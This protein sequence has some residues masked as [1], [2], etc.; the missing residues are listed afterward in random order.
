MQHHAS[1][2]LVVAIIV[3]TLAV[4]GIGAPR[5]CDAG[6]ELLITEFMALNTKTL[7]DE[8]GDYSDWIEIYNPCLADVDL[9]GWYLTD[10]EANLTKWQFPSVHL[11][12]GEYLRLFA[13][14]KNRAVAGAPL[15]TNFKLAS[16]G[17][18][19]ALVKPDG[20]TVAH[21]FSPAYPPQHSDVSYGLPQ[22]A[23]QLVSQGATAS[24]RVPTSDDS[25]LGTSW[26]A[27]GFDDSAWAAG[28]TGL[29][30]TASGAG[31]FAVTYYKA[32]ILVPDLATAEGVISDP[33]TQATVATEQ[34]PVINYL[35]TGGSAHY[36]N[37]RPFPGT[38]IGVDAD[39]FVVEATG[40]ILIPSAGPW[41]F[42]VNSDDGFSLDLWREPHDF[43]FS[44]SYPSP[45]GPAD[46]F[47]VFNIPEPGAY[48]VRLVFYER[49]GGSEVE[50]FAAQGSYSSFSSAF[51]LVGDAANGGLPL[52]NIGVE[53]KTNVQAAMQNVN[54]SL[55]SRIRFQVADPGRLSLLTLRMA[56]EDGFV[57]Y[58]NGVEVA[59]RDAPSSVSWNSTALSDR[60]TGDAGAFERIDLTNFLGLLQP[61]TNVLA[62]HGLNDA[63]ADGDFLVLP[64]LSAVEIT[65]DTGDRRY[66]TPATPGTFNSSGYPGV[67]GSPTFS[68]SS[69]VFTDSFSLTLTT[70]SPT[71]VVRYTLDGSEPSAT[72]GAV[73]SAPILI[74]ASTRIRARAFEAGLAPSSVITRFY[75]KLDA[76]V[77]GF[78]SNLPVLILD[79]FGDGVNQT[80]QTDVLT[81]IIPTVGGRASITGSPDF[82][83]YAGLRLRGSSSLGFPKN[84]YFLEIWDEDRQDRDV[85]F[86]GLPPQ[87]DWI[88]YG[89]Y[90][91]KSLMRNF[92]AYEWSNDIGRYAVR[93]RFVELY[94]R[95]A[96][97]AVSASD[98]YGV[99][100]LMEKI[101]WDVNRVNITQL[102]PTDSAPPEVTGGYIIKK[103]RLDPGDLGFRTIT[104]Q[105][106]NYVF[107]KEKNITTAQAAYLK[108]Y[109]DEFE[110]VLYGANFA[111]P[112][113]GYAKY[114]DVDSFIDHHIL[115]ELTKNIDGFR[116]S[117]FM[118]KDRNGKLNMGPL[119]DFDLALGNANYLNGWLPDG[120]Y[121]DQLNDGDYP[122]W[123]RLFSDPE[124]TQRY[125]D[126]WFAL[127]GGPLAT[128]KLL[129]DVDANAAL[130]GESE[131]R[132]FQR[133]PVLGVYVWPN[134]YIGAAYQDEIDWMKQWITGRVAWIDSQFVAPPVFNHAAGQ[135]PKWFNLTISASAGVIYYTLDGT[136]P[137]L[138]G[139][140]TSPSAVAYAGPL[141]IGAEARIRTRA[142]NGAI[143]SAINDATF[144][145]VPLVYVNE[146]LPQNVNCQHDEHGEFD[147]WIE[148]Y[149][150]ETTTADLS[151][152]F[153]TDDPTVPHK[154]SIPAGTKLCGL[155]VLL[156]W[157]DNEPGEGDLHTN[158]RLNPAG[159]SVLLFDQA[160]NLADSL[161][162]PALNV[163]VSYGRSPDGTSNLSPFFYATPAAPNAVA[164][165]RILLDEYNAVL[166]TKYLKNNGSDS[167]FGT[168][169]G[170][171]GDWFELVVVQDHLDIRGWKVLV[172]DNNVNYGPL[173]FTDAAILSD[174][175]SGTIIT[176]AADVPSNVSYD[177]AGGDW[178][179]SL[180]AG[181]SG[182][183]LYISAVPFS[184]SQQN[185]QITILDASGAL[186]FGPAGEGISPISGIGNDEVFKLQENPGPSATPFSTNYAAGSTSTFGTPNS[187][188]GGSYSQDFSVLRS[189]VPGPC[190]T[191]AACNDA[192]PCTDDACVGSRCQNTPNAAA[193][194]DGDPYTTNDACA[195]RVCRG[196]AA[197]GSCVSDCDCD[198]GSTCTTDSCVSRG[199]VNSLAPEGTRC[200]DANPCTVADACAAGVCQGAPMNCDDLDACTTDSCT[201][202]GCSHAVNGVCGIAGSV[203]YYRDGA[204]VAE[205][206]SKPVPRVDIDMTQDQVAEVCTDDAGEYSVGDQYG[207][208]TCSTLRKFGSP[209]A[210]D[211]NDAITSFDA[212]FIARNAVGL[213]TLSGNQRIAADVSGNGEVS[214]YDAAKVA[215]FA[216]Q[217]LDHFE[218]A[219][220]TGSDWRFLRCDHYTDAGYQD[221][222]APVYVHPRLTGTVT[223]DF[224]AILYGDVSGNWSA[225][226]SRAVSAEEMAA[227]EDR[228]EAER[229]RLSGARRASPPTPTRLALLTLTGWHQP[230]PAG[231]QRTVTVGLRNGDGIEAFDLRITYDPAR[232]AILDV[233]TVDLGNSFTL[234]QNGTPGAYRCGMYAVSPI[235]GSGALL[236]ITVQARQSLAATRPFSV[237]AKA[238]EGRIP[239]KAPL[240]DVVPGRNHIRPKHGE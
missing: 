22:A 150:P 46:S 127:R 170:N 84:Q 5:A 139:G 45:R 111:D 233:H 184:V 81:S 215:Q 203:R 85:S 165:T 51:Q 33:A 76:G 218:V 99:Y 173:V 21:A 125:A 161:A 77:V 199:C 60:P 191:D 83:G 238:N 50:L 126:R 168:A 208:V 135:V 24:Y 183:G 116:L 197:A 237:D 204:G 28:P 95:R 181:A 180:R 70:G 226:A 174:L 74:D 178:W 132:N 235:R 66:F 39:D 137:R 152:L 129:R 167:Y 182:D 13:S 14:D 138:A 153:L 4:A 73:Y 140:G 102:Q 11:A 118:F 9:G 136:D 88:L 31:K 62:I 217:L 145:P 67:S 57:A 122:W 10:D 34:A 223:D 35:N 86:L 115:V 206:S 55:W 104:G 131:V 106:L 200:D 212:T 16:E 1:P 112:V 119:W 169:M 155:H 108:G 23:Y 187:W 189:V 49:G 117:T 158:F 107:P 17:E 71:A 166:P 29:G 211:H 113:N 222:G 190:S 229:L 185:S 69:R 219:T 32:N 186:A 232:V 12:R 201:T 103:D 230:L 128:A 15:H 68:H 97:G 94:F 64:E 240:G 54:S 220:A 7:A 89:P 214:S 82:V 78:S 162:Y 3:V 36:A 100:V 2:W 26:A 192:N 202:G 143:W 123:R 96:A 93:T 209:R 27:V 124:F 98:Y 72:N 61:G 176:V 114:I 216:V 120:W 52:A 157:A 110:S 41:T 207:S 175:R 171:G 101:K 105:V 43:S 148:L 75:A 53:I 92:L 40:T 133:W 146:V 156:L 160:G 213:T 147:P 188:S 194:D 90:T 20:V 210:S 48:S 91:D 63:A 80:W 179:I 25:A 121:H 65:A 18:Y 130:L 59:S 30:F 198:D 236:S 37:D 205:P 142:L 44:M 228:V 56:Y 221:C 141:P 224:Y 151:G 195:N 87:S 6:V 79:T 227:S 42:G 38:Q 58:L 134:E 149:N 163:N 19:L 234:A 196:E 109:L 193:C 154:W 239:L 225:G 177:P 231:A 47:A 172:K 8:N 164:A 144:Q 159:G